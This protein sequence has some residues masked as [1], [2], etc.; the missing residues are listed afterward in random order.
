MYHSQKSNACLKIQY[1]SQSTDSSSAT[2]HPKQ[3][4]VNKPAN[5]NARKKS[6]FL[7]EIHSS[8]V[9]QRHSKI[10]KK[11]CKMLIDRFIVLFR[12]FLISVTFASL[13]ME[14][15]RKRCREEK[16]KTMRKQFYYYNKKKKTEKSEEHTN[17][18]VHKRFYYPLTLHKTKHRT[19]TTHQNKHK[20]RH[21]GHG[22][23]R[24]GYGLWCVDVTQTN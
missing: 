3:I 23:G 19:E 13:E 6:S 18:S 20:R 4:L 11:R 14:I 5:E 12:Y 16:N 8:G 17:K 15:R 1:N 21:C 9:N 10:Q 7:F 24:H 2:F 22:H